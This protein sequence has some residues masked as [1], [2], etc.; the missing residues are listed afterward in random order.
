MRHSEAQYETI[1]ETAHD[2]IWVLDTE[3][4]F[5]FVNKSGEEMSGYTLSELAGKSFA[6]LIHPEDLPRVKDLFLKIL[7]GKS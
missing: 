7:E 4:N 6:S 2:A 5:I 3:G 1:I